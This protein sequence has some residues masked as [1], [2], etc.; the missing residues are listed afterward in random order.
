MQKKVLALILALSML[1]SMLN[2]ALAANVSDFSD[3]PNDWSRPALERA[4]ENGLLSGTNGK[5]NASG[6]LTRAEMA[7]IVVRAFGASKK[8]DLSAYS[9]VKTSDWFYADMQKAVAM[10]VLSGSNGRLNPNAPI[11]REEVCAVLY[12]AFLLRDGGS[13]AQKFGD[14]AAI[15]S[16]AQPAVAAMTSGGHVAGDAYGNV[17]PGRTI[18]RAEFAQMMDNLVKSYPS[19]AVSGVINGNAVV[20]SANVDLT[21]AVIKGDLIL[22]DG[23]GKADLDLS[24]CTVEGRIIVRGGDT[25]KLSDGT[26]AE[27]V[28]AAIPGG[29]LTLAGEVGT[30]EV[31]ADGM[32]IV[33]DEDA[34]IAKIETA[35]SGTTIEGEGKVELV[36]VQAGASKTEV[37]TS[38]T[39]ITV[40]KNGGKVTSNNGSLS[41]GETGTTDN[42]GRLEAE[43]S[44]KPS[45]S[46]SSSSGS[47][48]KK[49]DVIDAEGKAIGTFK[50]GTTLTID[51]A[52]GTDSY[53]VTVNGDVKLDTPSREEYTFAGWTVSGKTITAR[54]TKNDTP[55]DPEKKQITVKDTTGTEISTFEEGTVLTIKNDSDD[56]GITVTVAENMAA[57]TVPTKEGYTFTGWTVSGA[58]VTAAWREATTPALVSNATSIYDGTNTAPILMDTTYKNTDEDQYAERTYNQILRAVGDFRQDIAMVNG[59]IDYK[60]VQTL[61]EDDSDKQAARLSAAGDK[62]PVLFQGSLGEVQAEYAIIVGTIGHSDMIQELIR[63]NKLSGT[64]AISGK[65]EA[66]TIQTVDNPTADIK[67]ALVVAGSDARG[68]IYG[69]YS[70]SEEIGVSPWYWWSDVPV[71]T[72]SKIEYSKNTTDDGPDVKY[73]GIFLNDEDISILHWAAQKFPSDAA[74][75]Q[76][77]NSKKKAPGVNYYRHVFE[78]MSRLRCNTIWPAMHEDSAAFNVVLD[79]DEIPV[80][81][82]TANDYA[83]VMASTHC[84]I[85]LR[86]NTGE[87]AAW[88]EKNAEKYG[89]TD[90]SDSYSKC[91]DFSKYSEALLQ[92]WRERL[93]TNKDF[94]SILTIGLR[95]MHDGPLM[96][97]DKSKYPQTSPDEQKV[98][99]MQDI[100]KAQRQLIEEVYKCDASEIPQVFIP[101]KEVAD[102]YNAGINDFLAQDEYSDITLMWAEDNYGYV[103]QVPNADEAKRS[104]GA[105]LYYHASYS[106]QPTSYLWL[107]SIQLSL[108]NEQ[109]QRAYNANMRDQW[110]LNVG[111][112]KPGDQSLECYAK[113]AWDIKEFAKTNAIENFLTEVSKRDYGLT[114]DTLKKAVGAMVEY[115]QLIGT[116]K[117]EYYTVQDNRF[118]FSTTSNGDE[119]LLW[120]KRC[121]SVVDD[122]T[123]VY[124][125]LK[126]EQKIA[127]YEQIYYH[128]LS[129]LDAAEEY[130]YYWKAQQAAEQGRVGSLEVYTDLSKKAAQNIRERANE[131]NTINDDKWSGGSGKYGKGEEVTGFMTWQH[132]RLDQSP[133]NRNHDII[134]DGEYPTISSERLASFSGI[135][136]AAE[137][138]TEAGSGTLNFNSLYTDEQ[139]YF[140]VFSQQ[141]GQVD[142]TAACSEDWIQLS[143]TSGATATEQ[144]VIVTVDWSK[145]TGTQTGTIQIYKGK[146]ATGDPVATFTVN[147]V[148]ATSQLTGSTKGY[149]EANGYVMIEAE[150]YSE[151]TPG[152]DGSTWTV[153]KSNAQ[154]GDTMKADDITP[155][156]SGTNGAKLTYNV[157]FE[158]AGTYTGYLYRVPTLNEGTDKTAEVAIGVAGAEPTTLSGQCECQVD[159]NVYNVPQT[160]WGRN[161]M[162]QCEPLKFKI[163][164]E[165]GWNTIELYRL[166]ASI[167]VDRIAIQTASGDL[168]PS[169]FGDAL[170]TSSKSDITTIQLDRSLLGPVTSPNNLGSPYTVKV[171][172]LPEEIG[173]AIIRSDMTFTVGDSETEYTGQSNVSNATSSETRVAEV[174]V[175]EGKLMV[176]P[177]QPGAASVEVTATEGGKE[178]T[179]T[180]TVTVI[181]KSVEEENLIYKP[182]TDGNIVIDPHDIFAAKHPAAS[183]TPGKTAYWGMNGI[184]VQ[185]LPDSRATWEKD[186][187]ADAPQMTFQIDAGNGGTFKLY[188]NTSNPDG[189]SD[190]YH[191]LVD[192]EYK[193]ANEKAGTTSQKWVSG[194]DIEL[195]A[196]KHSITIVPREDGF[197]LNQIALIPENG[198]AP[199][200][201]TLYT[202]DQLSKLGE[203]TEAAPTITL[204]LDPSGLNM[205]EGDAAQTITATASAANGKSVTITAASSADSIATVTVN[206]KEI[207]VTAVKEGSATI[208]VKANAD[209]CDEVTQTVRVTVTPFDT[210]EGKAYLEKDGAIVVNVA[211]AL[212]NMYYASYENKTKGSIDFTWKLLDDKSVQLTPECPMDKSKQKAYQWTDSSKVADEA[213]KLTFKVYAETDGNYYFSFFSNSPNASTDSFHIAVNGNYQYQTGD[214][215]G[216]GSAVGEEWFTCKTVIA[217]QAGENTI[218]IYEREAGTV[219]RQLM[220]STANPT[221]LAGTK[222]WKTS[223]LGEI[224]TSTRS[225]ANEILEKNETVMNEQVNLPEEDPEPAHD[226]PVKPEE[227][228]NS[229]DGAEASGEDDFT[230]DAQQEPEEPQ[231]EVT[232]P[233]A[234]SDDITDETA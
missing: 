127:F 120:L 68:T 52:N 49:Y 6:R 186:G 178:I 191:V 207:T 232:E 78:L 72:K 32:T 204:S 57:I 213:P 160:I 77:V 85:M 45:S 198:T 70:I 14:Y 11:T 94:E 117:P 147:A 36:E 75:I 156:S 97:G 116:K 58:V 167:V 134:F 98:A 223:T 122:L 192:G 84:D 42:A 133:L 21:G 24:S 108:M 181:P 112:I 229:E 199:S 106:G 164:V 29:E 126:S 13:A 153:V 99:Y 202:A 168:R 111:D 46:S 95:G 214:P 166:D 177:K 56:T 35:M 60:T 71:T 10:G 20:K 131:Y 93:E 61:M 3:M 187:L 182:N 53:T 175:E 128:A 34:E 115:Y 44:S 37:T 171:A 16:W 158:E 1:F 140:D 86:T 15:S 224:P 19:G 200:G 48:T 91:Y 144:R 40:D 26:K 149:Q 169:L 109:L 148:N 174:K 50:K 81:S 231:N 217:L 113:L 215:Q 59:G 136:A 233:A 132:V 184:G 4:I 67:K 62:A 172:E 142:W 225:A 9:D 66:F 63:T 39:E 228:T 28:I 212:N 154:R 96:F 64:D 33:A 22:A 79:K 139:H 123:D 30:V 222:V 76:Q 155:K 23:L 219:L 125:T 55:V 8:A 145:V 216:Y 118:N 163:T 170:L 230:L 5:I 173:S 100:I 161:V 206:D 87:W 41:A 2:T 151:Y 194:G 51:P 208:T 135:G 129:V 114:G 73:R 74:A 143:A 176:T 103:R 190:S 183:N 18:T 25:V 43:T 162:R 196:G 185:A 197:C 54:W 195:T 47:S 218:T 165:Q 17:N 31:K 210:G 92:Y 105:G 141:K 205:R 83:I 138:A 226:E 102:I 110:I 82:K 234:A 150:A 104:G 101:Y 188:V 12:R 179:F 90:S 88:A 211:D 220:F 201:T 119:A 221:G 189:A 152:D 107:N 209:G 7:S 130:V 65:W 80:N 193:Y 89:F 27:R 69:L 227:T 159:R 146:D 180:I 137:G 203:V 124:N 157:Y 38:K 121:Q